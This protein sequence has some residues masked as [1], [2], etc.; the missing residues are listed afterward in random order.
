ME[1]IEIG[2]TASQTLVHLQLNTAVS[3]T[4]MDPGNISIHEYN[5]SLPEE[6]I[7]RHPLAERDASKLLI[8]R[9]GA[10]SEDVFHNINQYIPEN[11]LLIF[12]NSKVIE[13]RILFQ[14]PTGGVIEIFCLEPFKQY[15]DLTSA[16][17]QQTD[18]RWVCLIGGA[19]KWKRGQLLEKKFKTAKQEI[20]L[21]ASFIEKEKDSFII[22]FQW[23]PSTMSFAEI[24][25]CA[26]RVP[27]PPYLKREPEKSD[28]ERY[29]T[30]YAQQNGSVAAPTAGLHFTDAIFKKL[31]EK[32]IRIDFVTLHVGAGTFKPVK[33]EKLQQHEMHAEFIDV[34]RTTIE[35][36]V[37]SI[38]NTLIP[39]GTTSL[40]TIE[41]LYWLGV[42]TMI[43]P[44]SESGL[45]LAQWEAYELASKNI[46]VTDALKS[47]L[48]WMIKNK[49]DRLFTKTQ[50]IIV[51]GYEI[52]IPHALIT[53]FH[54]PQSTLLL[55][56]AALIGEEW[57][58]VYG[59]ALQHGFR[60]LSYGDASL[61][62]FRRHA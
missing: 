42:K 35:N 4:F 52:K 44:G 49:M 3:C 28:T 58:K 23:T 54:Q 10:I 6:K 39:I 9:E 48:N 43:V 56:V 37:N 40:R 13:A 17:M 5:Y 30:I 14:K 36:L 41:T 2:C 31:K 57:R 33:S 46:P 16:F 8:Y 53:N 12:N 55:L 18:V 47:L 21:H 15:T 1:R 60:F 7:A 11:S 45:Q 22:E 32:N 62:W 24:L 19:S 61:L 34:S 29:Q 38:G 59:Y 25:H 26:G 50:L 51:P 20:I 27:I